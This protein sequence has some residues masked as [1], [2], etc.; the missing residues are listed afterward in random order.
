[1][2]D[3]VVVHDS[4]GRVIESQLLPIANSSLNIRDKY[5]KAYLG[6]SPAAKPKFWLAFPASVPPLGFNTYFV[7]SGKR[8]GEFLSFILICTDTRKNYSKA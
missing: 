4:E 3:S 7:S 6:T 5:T 8:S 2:S 1:M